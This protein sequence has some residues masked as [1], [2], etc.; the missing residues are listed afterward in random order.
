MGE[1]E[2]I[3]DLEAEEAEVEEG[4]ETR[5]AQKLKILERMEKVAR[6]RARGWDRTRIAQKLG[7]AVITIERDITRIHREY[8]RRAATS[9]GERIEGE[10]QQLRFRRNELLD[11]L[12]ASMTKTTKRI[13]RIGKAATDEQGNKTLT[14]ETVEELEYIP[15]PNGDPDIRKELVEINRAI[16]VMI[17]G[18]GLFQAAERDVAFDPVRKLLTQ[19][20]VLAIPASPPPQFSGALEAVDAILVEPKES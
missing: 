12:E 7:T 10:L 14:I 3:T 1:L 2:E 4:K 18:R 8:Q 15:T 17:R 9:E 11:E 13:K 20:G 19:G 16:V 6:L 5:A